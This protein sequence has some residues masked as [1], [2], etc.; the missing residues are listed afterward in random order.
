MRS[1]AKFIIGIAF[2]SVLYGQTGQITGRV[3]DQNGAVMPDVRVSIRET[4][5]N[6]TRTTQTNQDGYYS[7]PSL[8]PGSYAVTF[9]KDGFKP[10]TRSGLTLEVGQ[11][12]RLDAGLQLGSVSE[13]IEVKAEAP[14]LETETH[15]S[16][17][18]IQAR[19]VTELPLLGRDAYAL[20]ELVPGVRTSRGMND[21]PVDIISTASISINGA[22]GNANEFLLDGAP[23]SASSQNQPLFYPIADA[24]Q[25]FKV[26]TSNY[27]AEFGRAAGGVFNV[28]TKSGSNALH[29]EL[30]E[31]LR[32]ND[33]NANNYFANVAGQKIPPLKF[34]QFGGTFGGP[35]V[36][37]K[38]YNGH[39]KTFFYVAT[40]LVRYIQGVTYTATV[41]NPAYLSGNFAGDV[42]GSGQQVT[43]Y[44][45]FTTRLVNGTYVRDPFPG[46]VI[47]TTLLNPVAGN[48]KTYFPAPNNNGTGPTHQNNLMRTDSDV[49]DKNTWTE[50]LDHSFSENTRFFERYSYDDSP[51]TRASP[52]GFADIGSPGYGPQTFDRYNAVAQVDH[53]FSPTLIGT[54][55][56]S[57][58]RLTNSRGPIGL[59]FDLTQLG[60]PAGLSKAIGAPEAFPVIEIAGYTVASSVSNNSAAYSLGETG[61]IR[62]GMNNFALQGSFV[63]VLGAHTMKFGV[64]GRVVQN[65]AL[66]SADDS[67]NFTFSS[68]FT[69]G[70]NPTQSS[71]TAG[72][73]LAS[74]LL[75]L[76]ASGSVSPSPALALETKYVAGYLQ[77]DWKVTNTLTANLG[78]RYEFETPRQERYNQ[79]TNFNYGA[80]PPL[81]A[82]GLNLHGTLAFPGTGGLPIYESQLIYTHVSP[83]AG[84]AWRPISKTVIRSGAGIF[85]GNNWGVGSAP[86]TFGISGFSAVTS[87]VASQDGVTPTGSLSN[88]YPN[89]LNAAT[90][91]S[92]GG[93]T[94]L[95][96]S[97]SFYDR[98]NV[99]PYT[100]QYNF[101]VQREL[102]MGW[103]L[104]AGYVG[105]HGVKLQANQTLDQLPDS[106]LALGNALRTQVP[107]P[108]YG[109]IAVGSLASKTVAQA[110]L[111]TPYPQFTAVT[112]DLANWAGSR[113]NALQVK[114]EKKVSKDFSL[115]ASY[116]YSK[117]M[118]QSTGPFSG[119][120]LGGGAIQDWNNLK[121]EWSPSQLDQTHRLIV[122]AIVEL[123]FFRNQHTLTGRVLGGWELGILCS[124][125]SGSPLG[126][127]SAVNGTFS[128]GGGQR[129]N[130]TGVNP[131]LS[132]PTPAE[133]FNTSVF[134]TPAAYTFGNAPRTFDGARSDWTRQ[135]DLS[136]HKS[137]ALRDRLTLQL[138]GEA[139]NVSNTVVFAPPNTSFGSN[140]F[141][142]VSSQANQPRVFQ[143]A[144]KLIY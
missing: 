3:T 93:A 60:F 44:N 52:Y 8:L 15:S 31:F 40:E 46:N 78:L 105:T 86:S 126:V 35:V 41:P 138:R 54:L 12:A 74:F 18:V 81:N 119:E 88:P 84:F 55:R 112:S 144:M 98:S 58:S 28:V 62:L 59:G 97:V 6:T 73:A 135:A 19:Q 82:P 114:L 4:S 65:N 70:P 56:A 67:N 109:Q 85:Y 26:D 117:M 13:K 36:I 72:D 91:S 101:D 103:L 30:W 38:V 66:Q 131:G 116:T 107:N 32:N 39:N 2:A 47:P 79:L 43:I 111:L 69:Q 136:L 113:Y 99:T 115:L 22:Q 7:A 90:G 106:A 87:Y 80:V 108:F 122:N 48:L 141:G 121:A 63:K 29:F 21:L 77:D 124:F 76:P 118:D 33:L 16:G 123:P 14:V 5:T 92:L 96:Q 142:V 34:N 64:E 130:W 132:N 37:P 68:A 57:F 49:T 100:I 27:S 25:E 11:E 89:G 133:W 10:F 61:L 95:G 137:F 110:V 75:G 23:N 24:V 1:L 20:G 50:R 139:F 140:S 134:S 9:E 83:R 71:A 17:E 128:Q 129:P 143:I 94:L 104:D 53:V 125:Y 102:P 127:T 51:F 120:T 45:P 42:N